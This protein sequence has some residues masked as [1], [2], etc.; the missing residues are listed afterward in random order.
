MISFRYIY[1]DGSHDENESVDLYDYQK[2]NNIPDDF[3]LKDKYTNEQYIF[4]CRVCKCDSK[5]VVSLSAHVEG[6]KHTKKTNLALREVYGLTTE[7]QNAHAGAG[8]IIY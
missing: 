3:C 7:P 8:S 1:E 2:E 5:S 6:A 4:Y